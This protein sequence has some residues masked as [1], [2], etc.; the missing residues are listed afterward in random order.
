MS[1]RH[2]NLTHFLLKSTNPGETIKFVV[3]PNGNAGDSLIVY[4]TLLLLDSLGIKANLHI[5][6]DSFDKNDRIFYTGGGNFVPYYKNC[7][8]FFLNNQHVRQIV[9][10]P[11]TIDGQIDLLAKFGSNVVLFARERVSFRHLT[12]YMKYPENAYIDHDL[13]FRVGPTSIQSLTGGKVETKTGTGTL[14]AFRKDKETTNNH[15]IPSDNKD[16]SLLVING[17]REITAQGFIRRSRAMLKA[18]EPFEEVETDRL[19]V[20]IAS[21]L[22]GKNITLHRNSYFKNQ[23]VYD[24]SLKPYFSRIKLAQ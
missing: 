19:H 15:P 16:I 3:G 6:T 7:R 1:L 18:I 13:A 24:Y 12:K 11:H 23:A 20:A 4:G 17:D 8:E 5:P 22:L 14:H 21:A 10:L 2:E 9:L